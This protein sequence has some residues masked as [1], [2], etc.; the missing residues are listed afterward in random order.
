M[1]K[2]GSFLLAAVL[3]VGLS[4]T[5]TAQPKPGNPGNP[6]PGHV[7]VQHLPKM[8]ERVVYGGKPYYYWGGHFYRP[9]SGVYVSITAP[10]GAI[11]P[12]LP[13]GFV[14]IGSGPGSYYF[15]A[16]VYYR[17][18]PTGYVVIAQ[19]SQAPAV[20]PVTEDSGRIIVYPAAGQSE[21]QTGRDRYECHLWASKE[22][23]F[24]PTGSD[25]DASL[26]DDYRR[27]M[28]ACL[29]ARQYVVK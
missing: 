25:P 17:A 27:A 3:L 5:V 26:K 23:G 20:L 11:V 4:A 12:G 1:M 22:T 24:D 14:T 10:I 18:A 21:D 2:F 29:E 7:T 9:S 15:Y 6:A 13:G 28:S 8:H 16:G 19:P